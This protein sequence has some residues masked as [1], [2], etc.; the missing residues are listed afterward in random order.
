MLF[1]DRKPAGEARWAQDLWICDLW[2]NHHF[3]LKTRPP[4]RADLDDF[5]S[6]YNGEDRS[7]QEE[8]VRFRS[9]NY[10][11]L[12]KRDKANLNILW[13]R[14]ESME[15]PSSLPSRTSLPGRSW[16]IC[17]RRWSSLMRFQGPGGGTMWK[18]AWPMRRGQNPDPV[19]P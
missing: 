3:T 10:D 15:D 11:D 6:C 14:D 19:T 18:N 2:T 13:L 16:R 5:V 1:F 4:T 17:G 8:T 9:L 7:R 12:V